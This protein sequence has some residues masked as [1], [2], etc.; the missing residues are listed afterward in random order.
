[1]EMNARIRKS[2]GWKAPAELF[3]LEG[4]FNFVEFWSDTST[5]KHVA[6]RP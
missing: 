2:L 4:E 1:M 5:I 6:L 3:L